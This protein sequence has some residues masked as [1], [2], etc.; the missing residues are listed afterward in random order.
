MMTFAAGV[1]VGQFTVVGW[2][3]FVSWLDRIDAEEEDTH[4]Q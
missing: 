2:I 4:L 1:A 3:A